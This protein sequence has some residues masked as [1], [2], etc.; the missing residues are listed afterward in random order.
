MRTASQDLLDQVSAAQGGISDYAISKLLRVSSAAVSRWRVGH[1]HM[2]EANITAACNL[3][4]RYPNIGRWQ[5]LIG[6]EREKGPDGDYYRA[7]R[8]DFETLDRGGKLDKNS[9]L[10][11]FIEGVGGIV[12]G[13]AFA[14]MVA[15]GTIFAPAG[16]QASAASFNSSAN[17]HYA[18]Y[19][20]RRRRS[21]RAWLRFF[22]IFP[23]ATLAT[24]CTQ[25]RPLAEYQHLSHATQHFG[26]NRT[27]YGYDLASVGVRWRPTEAVTVDLL[28][29][30]SLQEM[31]GRREVFSGRVTVEFGGAR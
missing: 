7:M 30:Y 16:N 28:E 25:L 8:R 31:H 26:D 19:G 15:A 17:I 24:A 9:P 4:G 14:A 27:N 3:L 6:A 21:L 13:W 5:Y 20:R 29:G 12:A 11:I 10:R 2:S 1:S 22:T 23:V 18:S